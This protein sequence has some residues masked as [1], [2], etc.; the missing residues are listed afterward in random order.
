MVPSATYRCPPPPPLCPPPPPLW[1]PPPPLRVPPPPPL[2]AGP[3]LENPWSLC[4]RA[5]PPSRTP[6]KA[7]PLPLDALGAICRLP[8]RSPPDAEVAPRDCA[9]CAAARD[10]RFWRAA[11]P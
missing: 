10:C 9:C 4:A 8:I 11:P 5:A 2:R 6:P 7:L 1:P 3:R